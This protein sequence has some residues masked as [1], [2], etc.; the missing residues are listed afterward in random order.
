MLAKLGKAP[1]GYYVFGADRQYGNFDRCPNCGERE[2]DWSDGDLGPYRPLL[3]VASVVL[4]SNHCGVRKFYHLPI[5]LRE[6]HSDKVISMLTPVDVVGNEIKPMTK[7]LMKRYQEDGAMFQ[8]LDV[9]LTYFCQQ[10]G[11]Y[12]ISSSIEYSERSEF[13]RIGL[14]FGSDSL[15]IKADRCSMLSEKNE[16]SSLADKPVYAIIDKV[17]LSRSAY[18]FDSEDENTLFA[19]YDTKLDKWDFSDMVIERISTYY[20]TK[21]TTAGGVYPVTLRGDSTIV[22]QICYKG[23]PAIK[24]VE[25]PR[26]TAK[27]VHLVRVM[28]ELNPGRVVLPSEFDM[29]LKY[30]NFDDAMELS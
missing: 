10:C 9:K 2:I 23:S 13:N 25:I 8:G 24:M 5:T 4:S 12:I 11:S 20:A 22:G 18:E 30:S 6:R 1:N 17:P 14:E 19:I 21:A 28:G 29:L 3:P 7:L 27:H 15:I 26:S 16:Y